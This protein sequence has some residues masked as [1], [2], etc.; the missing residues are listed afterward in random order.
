MVYITFFDI[1]IGCHK[2]LLSMFFIYR[3]Y[4]ITSRLWL[5]II[6]FL[7][8]AKLSQSFTLW[9]LPVSIFG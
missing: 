1:L 4:N 6:L 3:E 2:L 9:W 7:L 5:F 8:L